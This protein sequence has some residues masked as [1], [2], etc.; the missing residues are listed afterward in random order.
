[1]TS[2]SSAKLPAPEDRVFLF[3]VIAVSLAFAWILRPFY[4]AVLWGV[5]IAIVFVPLYRRLSRSMRQRRTLAAI[6]TMMIILVMV[7]LPLTLVVTLLVQEAFGTYERIQSGDLNIGRYFQQVFDALPA[8]VTGLLDRVGLT[9]LG[10]V[11]E[12]LSAGLTRSIQFLAAQA[13]N[14][15]QNAFDF[16]VGLF[17]MLYLLFFLLRDGDDLSRRIKSAIPL[18]PEQQRNLSKRFAVV[19]RATVKGNLVV[20]VIQGALGALI[21][22][23]LG[24]HAPVLWGALMAVL[25]LLPAVGA[26][27]VWLPVAIYF[28]ATGATWQGVI[29]TAYGALVIGSVD[30]ILRPILVGKDT[31]MPDYVV[32]IST[33]GGIAVFGLNG[34]VI[35][36]V[37]AAM[38]MAVWDIL[39]AS[40]SGGPLDGTEVGLREQ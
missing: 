2:P 23:L 18:H 39:S 24:I 12:R 30:N 15:G 11:Q 28:L 35:G 1:M 32:L 7:I 31:K 8:W 17:V 37:I 25:S 20:A 16:V 27:V 14:I 40:R 21:F 29:L 34:F 4:G 3:L 6:T 5:I 36:P 13:L 19:I 9:S 22:W 38:F 26:A 10:V 33:L